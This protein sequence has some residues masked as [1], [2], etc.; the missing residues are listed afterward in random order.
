MNPKQRIAYPGAAGSYT[1][2]AASSLY[3]GG[4]LYSAGSFEDVAR[5][6]R[7]GSATVGVLPIENSLAGLVTETFEILA[8]GDLSRCSPRRRSTSRTAS[9]ACA[10]P[11]ST[12]SAD[13]LPPGGTD[14]VPAIR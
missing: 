4:D 2:E 13:P 11:R 8:E 3:P 7:S 6:V 10:A 9:R 1:A 12:A 5:D 14:A